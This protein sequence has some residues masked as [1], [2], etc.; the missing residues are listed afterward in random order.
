MF[1]VKNKETRAVSVNILTP[2]SSVS[3]VKFEQVN[4]DWVFMFIYLC[5]Y[6]DMVKI[7]IFLLIKDSVRG[8]VLIILLNFLE[9]LFYTKPVRKCFCRKS[10]LFKAIV[11][12][13]SVTRNNLVKRDTW[14]DTARTCIYYVYQ[15]VTKKVL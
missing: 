1:K 9:H 15:I 6:V 12:H 8:V 3:I 7:Y 11:Y 13:N 5:K 4:T 14:H 10:W 2:C